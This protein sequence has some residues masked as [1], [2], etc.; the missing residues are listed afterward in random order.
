MILLLN[1]ADKDGT[2]LRQIAQSALTEN[3][4]K[5]ERQQLEL[6]RENAGMHCVIFHDEGEMAYIMFNLWFRLCLSAKAFEEI[7]IRDEI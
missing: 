2:T 4:N 7:G 3:A 1:Y 6:D 5:T